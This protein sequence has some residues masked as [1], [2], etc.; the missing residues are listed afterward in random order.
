MAGLD[1]EN[2]D[3][4]RALG[5]RML[6]EMLDNVQTVASGPVW[7]PMPPAV[8]Q[9]FRDAELPVQETSLTALYEQ[10]AQ[11]VV[12]YA[13]GNR[14]PRFMGWVHGGGTAQGMLAE[15]LA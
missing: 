8:R 7:Q 10:F 4:L 11:S 6:D 5:H 12:P 3:A 2:W 15:L 1:P 14:H 9:A 13:T